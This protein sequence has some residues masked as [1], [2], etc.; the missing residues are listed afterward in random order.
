[1]RLSPFSKNVLRLSGSTAFAQLLP[2]L[3]APVLARLYAPA[4]FGAYYF[5]SAMVAMGS[6]VSTGRYEMAVMLPKSERSALATLAAGFVFCTTSSIFIFSLLFVSAFRQILDERTGLGLWLWFIPLGIWLQG[7][8]NLFNYWHNRHKRFGAIAAS[9]FVLSG[10]N[11]FGRL[12]LGFWRGGAGGLIIGTLAAW[13]AVVWQFAALF[14]AKDGKIPGGL[15][16]Q[17]IVQQARR[18]KH[19]PKNMVPGSLFNKGSS[20]LPVLLLSWFFLPAVAGWYGQMMAVTR[21]PIQVIGRSFEEVFR[22]AAAEE[23]H[24]Q[25]HCRNI[26]MRT[27]KKLFLLGFLPFGLFALVAPTLFSVVFGNDWL[28]A[29]YY[30]RAF[31]LP[32]FLQFISAPLSSLFYLR[33]QVGWYSR[34]ELFQLVLVVFSLF[35][36]YHFFQSADVALY[37]LAIAY[38]LGFLVRLFLLFRIVR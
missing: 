29:G 30:A 20:E 8:F 4:E 9:K 12:G 10:I 28:Q 2:L 6:V 18:Y 16:R 14:R 7:V 34:L 24:R 35:L 26:F 23:I 37:L 36:G 25:G 11:A 38:T 33:E 31:A 19:F 5:F 21:R 13:L 27:F 1:M 17:E 3:V 22:Q 32:L 15:S